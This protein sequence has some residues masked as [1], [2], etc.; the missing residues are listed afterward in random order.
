MPAIPILVVHGDKY[1]HV[2][3]ACEQSFSPFVGT[4]KIHAITVGALFSLEP[5]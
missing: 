5:N 1:S 3:G 4:G 2:L